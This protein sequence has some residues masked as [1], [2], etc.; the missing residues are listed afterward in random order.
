[1]ESRIY[2]VRLLGEG[3][4]GKKN[5]EKPKILSQSNRGEESVHFPDKECKNYR[6]SYVA[7]LNECG[8]LQN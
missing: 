3:Q 5:N 8:Q 2:Y 7:V 1:M 4:R 6:L